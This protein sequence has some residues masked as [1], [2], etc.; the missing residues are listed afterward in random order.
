MKIFAHCLYLY[1]RL[2]LYYFCCINWDSNQIKHAGGNVCTFSVFLC[3]TASILLL[4]HKYWD[5]N[6]IKHA[7]KTICSFF[8]FFCQITSILLL[9]HKYWYTNQMKHVNWNICTLFILMPDSVFAW[10]PLLPC[11]CAV[12]YP[13]PVSCRGSPLKKKKKMDPAVLLSLIHIW[14][15]RRTG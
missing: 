12:L 10:V 14:R 3:Q 11:L 2:H 6:Q 9:L 13:G 15:C 4:L 5:T 1:A 8:V 7:N